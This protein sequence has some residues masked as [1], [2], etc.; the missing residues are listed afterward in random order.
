MATL[1]H[2]LREARRRLEAAGLDAGDAAFDAD[3]LARHALG[4]VDRGQLIAWQRDDAPSDFAATFDVL[5]ARRAAREPAAYILGRREFWHLEF[6]VTPDTLIPRPETELIVEEVLARA[7]EG[8]LR[9]ADVCT[10]SGCLA[11]AIAHARPDVRIVATDLSVA[12]LAVAARNAAAHGVADHITFRQADLMTGVDGPFDIIVSNP[13][14]VASTDVDGAQPE[15]RDFEPRLA[16]DGGADGL[17]LARRLVPQVAERLV[18][19]GWGLFE[20]GFGQADGV[21]AIVAAEPRLV[22]DSIRND[23]A[24]IPRTAIVRR[25]VSPAVPGVRP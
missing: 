4:G 5:V 3:L 24:G 18:P 1:A 23:Y 20:F 2:H 8:P 16:L 22:L 7:L 25:A 13:P 21:R 9:L 19:G 14:Y 11:V 15:V 10:G 12:A 6:E 17:E